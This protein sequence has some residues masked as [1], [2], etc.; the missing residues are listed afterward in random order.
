[1]RHF[2][3]RRSFRKNRT[4]DVSRMQWNFNCQRHSNAVYEH[5]N[6]D[7]K[8]GENWSRRSTSA[9]RGRCESDKWSIIWQ[10]LFYDYSHFHPCFSS[11]SLV[12]F[13]RVL[14]SSPVLVPVCIRA[15]SL[16]PIHPP[17]HRCNNLTLA[18]PS[19]QQFNFAG[20]IAATNPS[21]LPP[22]LESTPAAHCCNN[23]SCLPSSLQ[24]SVT[25]DHL[26]PK[27]PSLTRF[28]T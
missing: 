8:K 25:M 28:N 26:V 5:Q 15:S 3:T 10:L 13:S 12:A 27:N 14:F 18:P 17:P 22:L 21:L 24:Q 9:I 4:V 1:M 6:D 2:V 16:Q 7:D 23:Q 20:S 11:L 19:L